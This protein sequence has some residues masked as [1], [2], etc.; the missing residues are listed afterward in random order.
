MNFAHI[1][2]NRPQFVKLALLY[3]ELQRR[4]GGRSQIIHTG[5]HFDPD[6]SDIF[7]RQL[8]IPLPDH[9]LAI[10]NLSHNEM[11]GNMLIGIDPLLATERPDMVV[12][13]GDTN[14]TLAGALA[15]KKRN[16]PLAHVESGIRTGKENMPEESNRYLTDRMAT[17]NFACT[18]LG[19]ENLARE[20]YMAGEPT[21]DAGPMRGGSFNCGDLMLDAALL[22]KDQALKQSLVLRERKMED[23]PFILA[24][25]HRAENTDNETALR[26]I[27]EALNILHRRTPVLFPMHPR[28]GQ[29]IGSLGLK[30]DFST[31]GP[32]GY[33][34]MLALVQSCSS[35]ITDS[36][37]LSREAYFFRKPALVIMQNPFWPELFVHGNCLRADAIAENIIGMQQ[38][39]QPA[40][41]PSENNIFG[42]GHAAA[43]ISEVLTREVSGHG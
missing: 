24:T 12:V 18:Y 19:M 13:Y 15:A 32:L 34:D 35:V 38:E 41:R 26:N 43:K 21:P 8:G 17:W 22:F 40:G 39:L 20:G 42:D 3:P 25:I 5:Q 14:T 30:V 9:Q 1:V 2:G 16:I 36:G 31:T 28:T 23:R 29:L 4:S 6:M 27:V 10:R 7:F 33:L 37:G 11:I